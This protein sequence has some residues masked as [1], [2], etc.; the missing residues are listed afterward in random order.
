MP[1]QPMPTA[2]V[3]SSS[4]TESLSA[5]AAVLRSLQQQQRAGRQKA[6]PSWV[7]RGVA[8]GLLDPTQ[9]FDP[10]TLANILCSCN[11]EMKPVEQAHAADA[12]LNTA[13][14]PVAQAAS[15][16]AKAATAAAVARQGSKRSGGS[17]S[18]VKYSWLFGFGRSGTASAPTTAGSALPGLRGEGAWEPF[19]PLDSDAAVGVGVGLP[20]STA[21]AAAASSA[22]PSG[23][24]G[25]GGS[26]SKAAPA[27][28]N[29]WGS[30]WGGRGGGGNNSATA[31][32]Q[33]GVAAPA[34]LRSK[35]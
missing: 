34:Q 26:G 32:G 7:Q 15:A 10:S 22:S 13:T 27:P 21:A 30:W 14:A 16:A 3:G 25:S 12:V 35:L 5:G 28:A 23:A 18:N 9:H 11:P 17:G 24:S 19:G 29:R 4:T 8:A 2:G 6:L 20:A 33:P 1:Q 31:G